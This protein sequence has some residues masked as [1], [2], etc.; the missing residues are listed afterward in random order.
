MQRA[1]VYELVLFNNNLVQLFEVLLAFFL[2]LPRRKL[3]DTFDI[4]TDL[5]IKHLYF[6]KPI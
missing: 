2:V 5:K 1:K 4:Q 3:S 6:W